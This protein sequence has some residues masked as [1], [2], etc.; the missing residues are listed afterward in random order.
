MD[1][2]TWCVG[3]REVWRGAWGLL[4]RAQHGWDQHVCFDAETVPGSLLGGSVAWS[5]Q[6]AWK[7]RDENWAWD[8]HLMSETLFRWFWWLEIAQP[9]NN[10]TSAYGQLPPFHVF[11]VAQLSQISCKNRSC[12]EKEVI[13]L[14]LNEYGREKR[15]FYFIFSPRNDVFYMFWCWVKL[16]MGC[17]NT[18]GHLDYCQGKA[19]WSLSAL[20]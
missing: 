14:P 12:M 2:R 8:L 1:T 10:K 11:T 19:A 16:L 6:T 20:V 17:Y 4:W 15:Y 5:I 3:Q 13:A 7:G 18:V 9:K